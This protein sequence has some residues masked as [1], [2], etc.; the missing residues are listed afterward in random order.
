[1]TADP[2]ARGAFFVAT[3]SGLAIGLWGCTSPMERQREED[4]RSAVVETIRSELRDAELRPE[5]AD[6]FALIGG[7][8]A[9]QVA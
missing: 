4:L 5:P 6:L 9:A 3:A 1:M 2:R 7:I 8:D